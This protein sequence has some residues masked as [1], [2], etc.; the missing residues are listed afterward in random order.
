M[1]GGMGGISPHPRLD[2][3]CELTRQIIAILSTTVNGMAD[4]G[5]PYSGFLYLGLMVTSDGVAYVIEYNCRLG[6]PEAQVILP[7]VDGDF[8]KALVA[9]AT[10]DFSRA[11]FPLR[12]EN[13]FG[14]VVASQGYPGSELATNGVIN[15]LVQIENNGG[16]VF[17]AS[18]KIDA[19]GLL[20]N[21]GGRVLMPVRLHTD[22]AEARRLA[23]VD[24][25]TIQFPGAWFRKDIGAELVEIP[26]ENGTLV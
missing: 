17:Q 22:L 14:F 2:G 7:R 18:T 16:L 9:F 21:S 8:G 24:A 25:L 12:Q 10:G 6:D 26:E 19:T 13:A 1:T 3:N 11:R 5:N 15:G 20:V 4:A 23:F